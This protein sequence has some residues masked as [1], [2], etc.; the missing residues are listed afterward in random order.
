MS[1][2][3]FW[4]L[5]LLSIF[6]SML[7]QALIVF[8]QFFILLL[9]L[10]LLDE[11]FLEFELRLYQLLLDISENA[12]VY[13]PLR[14]I[15]VDFYLLILHILSNSIGLSV[16]VTEIVLQLFVFGLKPTQAFKI[17]AISE[18]SLLHFLLI[19]DIP[20]VLDDGIELNLHHTSTTFLCFSF[21]SFLASAVA[22]CFRVS[23]FSVIESC[24]D[25]SIYDYLFWF[26]AIV[27][28]ISSG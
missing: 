5:L 4:I 22:F 6:L 17:A 16:E 27:R 14:P 18:G 20:E 24:T 19:D 26:K 15:L 28:F 7:L 12:R 25:A 8:E 11:Q 3:I 21:Y 2:F 9:I 10:D 13:H 23:I 1:T